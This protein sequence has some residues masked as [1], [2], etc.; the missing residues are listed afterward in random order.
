MYSLEFILRSFYH[1]SQVHGYLLDNRGQVLVVV[2]V[3]ISIILLFLILLKDCCIVYI[4]IVWN[5]NLPIISLTMK[6]MNP[7]SCGYQDRRF[8][9]FLVRINIDQATI[10]FFFSIYLTLLIL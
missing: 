4:T 7:S 6:Y 5:F 8:N 10:Y 1:V 3:V 2:A 9:F